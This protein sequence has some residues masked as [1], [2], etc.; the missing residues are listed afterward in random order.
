M[1]TGG[2][3]QLCC[4]REEEG[5]AFAEEDIPKLEVGG[6]GGLFF[7]PSEEGKSTQSRHMRRLGGTA[8]YGPNMDMR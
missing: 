1:H 8:K 3:G 6:V 4:G 5:E 2:P 7:S